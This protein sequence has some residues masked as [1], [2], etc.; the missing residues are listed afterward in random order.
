MNRAQRRAE[1]KN[2]Q[3]RGV[4]REVART[5]VERYY[6]DIPLEEGTR[7]KINYNFISSWFAFM[8]ILQ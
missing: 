6:S 3:K 2:L 7:V 8:A 1:V 5:L 4:K